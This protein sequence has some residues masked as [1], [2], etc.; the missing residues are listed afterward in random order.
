MNIILYSREVFDVCND[1]IFIANNKDSKDMSVIT[2]K[3]EVGSIIILQYLK[4]IP[5]LI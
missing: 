3:L 5:M 4:V 1:R 2:I